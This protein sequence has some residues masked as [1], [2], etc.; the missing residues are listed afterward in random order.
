MK[1]V[2]FFNTINPHNLPLAEALFNNEKT[3]S[4]T[5]IFMDQINDERKKL[6]WNSD[7]NFT[8]SLN[9]SKNKNLCIDLINDCD[10]LIYGSNPGYFKYVNRRIKNNR[11]TYCFSERLFKYTILQF[12]YPKYFIRYLTEIIFPS[13][14]KN[15]FFLAASSYLKYDLK[16]IFAFTGRVINFGYFPRVEY[17]NELEKKEVFKRKK[18]NILW[19]G[20]LLKWKNLFKLITILEEVSQINKHFDFTIVGT[21]KQK[22]MLEKKVKNSVLKINFYHGLEYTKLRTLMLNSHIGFLTSSFKEGWGV[23]SN[24]FL[25]SNCILFTNYQSGSSQTL[26]KNNFNGL[27]ININ[28]K[29]TCKSIILKVLNNIQYYEEVAKNGYLSIINLWNPTN[30][31]QRLINFSFKYI[32]G[33]KLDYFQDGPFS[34]APLIKN[35]DYIKKN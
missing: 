35:Y 22:V 17:I 9:F 3:T 6:G 32:K 31:A 25:N 33:D 15:F 10:V 20:R 4:L 27:I 1:I 29:E 14:K 19:A 16:R 18:I 8:N 23:I 30:A 26:V 21:G 13:Y 28:N 7:Y 2:Y 24:E 5:F 34:L 11:L 12:L